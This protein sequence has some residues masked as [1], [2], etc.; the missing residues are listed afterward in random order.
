MASVELKS[1]SASV[2][3]NSSFAGV[4]LRRSSASVELKL[5]FDEFGSNLVEVDQSGLTLTMVKLDK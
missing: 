2:E 4:E 5:E 1:S 3:L